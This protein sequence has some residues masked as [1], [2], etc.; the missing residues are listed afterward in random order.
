MTVPSQLRKESGRGSLE[1][2]SAQDTVAL[3]ARDSR[4]VGAGQKEPSFRPECPASRLTLNGLQV[5]R[6]WLGIEQKLPCI[7]PRCKANLTVIFDM[8]SVH[9]FVDY[10]RIRCPQCNDVWE[11]NVL[12]KILNVSVKD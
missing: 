1:I 12:G 2:C 8:N 6:S 4:A 3:A 7:N 9:G 11:I 5:P 10:Q